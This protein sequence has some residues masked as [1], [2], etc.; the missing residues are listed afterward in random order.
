MKRDNQPHNH[1][2]INGK[3]GIFER[4]MTNPLAELDIELVEGDMS[5]GDENFFNIR[6]DS[7]EDG[8]IQDFG[9]LL[10]Q[11]GHQFSIL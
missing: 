10:V 4:E 11:I 1:I 9:A 2:L 8:Q 7:P 3:F 5:S 6:V